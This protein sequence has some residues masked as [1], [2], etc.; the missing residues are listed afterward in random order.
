MLHRIMSQIKFAAVQDK[1]RQW[2]SYSSTFLATVFR[3]GRQSLN[4]HSRDYVSP[5]LS[6]SA[7]GSERSVRV[8]CECPYKVDEEANLAN[9]IILRFY[10]NDDFIKTTSVDKECDCNI[11]ALFHALFFRERSFT[12]NRQT[13]SCHISRKV[14]MTRYHWLKVLRFT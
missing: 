2:F 1:S 6:G 9:K 13:F 4:H 10:K 3:F 12:P 7:V 5:C 8:V 11:E 14:T